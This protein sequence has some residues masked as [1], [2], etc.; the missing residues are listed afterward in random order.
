MAEVDEKADAAQTA[1]TA[2]ERV[3]LLHPADQPTVNAPLTVTCGKKQGRH[4]WSPQ[5][6]TLVAGPYCL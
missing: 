6:L 4:A 3:L 2:Y 5:H 1:P